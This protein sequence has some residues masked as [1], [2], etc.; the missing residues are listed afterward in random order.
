M[1][2]ILKYRKYILIIFYCYIYS[3]LSDTIEVVQN[4]IKLM[5]NEEFGPWIDGWFE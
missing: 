1:A 2:I 3:G 5:R 4:Y